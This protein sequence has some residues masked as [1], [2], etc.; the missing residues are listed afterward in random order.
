MSALLQN[1]KLQNIYY[2]FAVRF[3]NQHQQLLA[4]QQN[5]VSKPPPTTTLGKKNKKDKENMSQVLRI[6]LINQEIE[7]ESLF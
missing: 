6:S 3:Y 2:C 4:Q 5:D 1:G 7:L